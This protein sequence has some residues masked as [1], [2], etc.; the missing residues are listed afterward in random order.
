MGVYNVIDL[1]RGCPSCGVKVEW[2]TKE[3]VI[4]N[5]YPVE[6]V[7]ETFSLNIR[8]S[9]EVHTLCSKCGTWTEAKMVNGKLIDLK[10]E[11]R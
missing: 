11:K 3:L 5:I 1:K 8:M 9:G 6:N 2:Q 4:D 10:T 7:L